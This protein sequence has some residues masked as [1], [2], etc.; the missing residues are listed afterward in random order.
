MED[1]TDWD[2]LRGIRAGL[3]KRVDIYQLVIP[4]SKLTDAQKTELEQYRT[5]LLTLPQDYAT[6]KLAYANI[7]TKPKWMN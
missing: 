5:D 3:L 6:P 1:W 7:P 4:Y 2:E